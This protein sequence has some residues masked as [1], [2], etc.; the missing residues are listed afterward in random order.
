MLFLM[1]KFAYNNIKNTS[2]SYTSFELNCDFYP[3]T[4]YKKDVNLCF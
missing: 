1:A 4:F 3:Q 2:I